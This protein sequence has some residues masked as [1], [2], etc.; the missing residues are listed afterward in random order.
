M[1]GM[2]YDILLVSPPGRFRVDIRGRVGQRVTRR[3][4]LLAYVRGRGSF[5]RAVTRSRGRGCDARGAWLWG[6]SRPPD[7]LGTG[8]SG[9]V[10]CSYVRRAP[11]DQAHYNTIYRIAKLEPVAPPSIQLF[12]PGDPRHNWVS[13]LVLGQDDPL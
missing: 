11:L 13:K 8:L 2:S 3:G 9:F 12:S 6:V 4:Y 10:V 5:R 7:A 1:C